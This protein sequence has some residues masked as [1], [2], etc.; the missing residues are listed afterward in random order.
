MARNAS[1]PASASAAAAWAS[2]TSEMETRI[3]ETS[4]FIRKEYR[5]RP[6]NDGTA[7]VSG[8]R[9]AP[10]LGASDRGPETENAHGT[11]ARHGN[12]A[13]DARRA[14]PLTRLRCETASRWLRRLRDSL[15]ARYPTRASYPLR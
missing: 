7:E 4:V 10:V 2:E 6:V 9:A 3:A 13:A 5:R 12:S 15:R 1:W 11:S 8:A 14:G